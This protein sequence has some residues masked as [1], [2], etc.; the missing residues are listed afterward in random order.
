[1]DEL[2]IKQEII[3]NLLI[4]KLYD[5]LEV[6]SGKVVYDRYN[7]SN[8]EVK[9]LLKEYDEKRFNTYCEMLIESAKKE[10]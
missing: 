6:E 7:L 5:G 4:E 2:K 8:K 3:I 1:M 10:D 9:F